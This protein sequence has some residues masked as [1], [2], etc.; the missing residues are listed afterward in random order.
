[1]ILNVFR[2]LFSAEKVATNHLVISKLYCLFVTGTY[3][4]EEYKNH[5]EKSAQFHEMFQSA[6]LNYFPSYGATNKIYC[7]GNLLHPAYKGNSITVCKEDRQAFVNSLI[8]EHPNHLQ[9]LARQAAGRTDNVSTSDESDDP[10]L[11]ACA[12]VAAAPEVV[13]AKRSA[14]EEEWITYNAM[15]IEGYHG[16]VEAS[17]DI[18][19]WWKGK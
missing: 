6:V 7:Y 10:M 2:N 8:F 13:I 5:S 19:K 18:L 3:K 17:K 16:S 12:A 14:I 15:P 11:A 1:M 4:D 9:F